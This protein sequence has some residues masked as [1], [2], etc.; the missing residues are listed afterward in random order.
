MTTTVTPL[1]SPVFGGSPEAVRRRFF[2][3]ST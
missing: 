1:L 3:R 2:L